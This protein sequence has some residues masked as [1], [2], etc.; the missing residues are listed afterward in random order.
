MTTVIGN[1]QCYEPMAPFFCKSDLTFQTDQARM[2]FYKLSFINEEN[3]KG[4][5]NKENLLISMLFIN[6]KGK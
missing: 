5:L 1:K 3:I 6:L 2:F 4:T